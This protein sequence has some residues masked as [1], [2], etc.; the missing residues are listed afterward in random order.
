MR[1]TSRE[2]RIRYSNCWEDATVVCE[3]L[4][5]LENARCLSIAS[6]GDNTLSL[7]GR[8]AASVV[9]VDRSFAQLAL[10][11]LKLCAF[12]SF[13][14]PE[15]LAFLGA[16]PSD[17]RL[18]MYAALREWLRDEARAFWDARRPELARGVLHAGRLEQYFGLFRRFALPL[19]HGRAAVE[20]LLA[21]AG[22]EERARLYE[23][24]WDNPRWRA[25]G[26][27]FFSRAVLGRLGRDPELFRFAEGPVAQTLLE[28][29]REAFTLSPPGENPYLRY[30]LTGDFGSA[31]PD[32]LRPENHAAIRA[33][34][35][36]VRLHH[37]PAE[38]ALGAMAHGIDAFNLSN[39]AEYME[40][41]SYH[42]LLAEVRRAAAP[43]ARLAYWNLLA[44]R[45]RPVSM[46]GWLEDREIVAARL[47]RASRAFFYRSFVLEVVR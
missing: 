19:T 13:S 8:G 9:A 22:P 16:R 6:A 31:L 42:R 7:L 15:V 25:V 18:S 14:H 29:T 47:H 10:V 35:G 28:G 37:G 4:A 44:S 32:Y 20:R 46:A 21:P 36:R 2:R 45:R 24:I 40:V 17:E 34:V 1:A 5:P 30:I 39:I 33:G 38:D 43:G 11:E 41:A 26:R 12:R 23:Q 27:V 3:A